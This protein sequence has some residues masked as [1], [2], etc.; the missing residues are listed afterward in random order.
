M[1]PVFYDILAE[2]SYAFNIMQSLARHQTYEYYQQPL[3]LARIHTVADLER[4]L[5]VWEAT[6]EEER[7][8]VSDNLFSEQG[9]SRITCLEIAR[10]WVMRHIFSEFVYIQLLVWNSHGVNQ[11][12]KAQRLL[13]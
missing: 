1:D 2:R 9:C 3:T 8:R 5:A 10:L 4:E 11:S 13:I 6:A 12:Q 7:H